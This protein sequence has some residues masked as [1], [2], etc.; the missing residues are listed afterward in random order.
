MPN[1]IYEERWV[2]PANAK[3]YLAKQ[4]ANRPLSYSVATRYSVDMVEDNWMDTGENIKLNPDGRML[5]GQHRMQAIILA[6]EL[7]EREGKKFD[8]LYLTFALNVPNESR[9]AMDIGKK[10]TLADEIAFEGGKDGMRVAAIVAWYDAFENANYTFSSGGGRYKPTQAQALKRWRENQKL[11]HTTAL[12]ATDTYRQGLGA[13]AP[14]GVAY[15]VLRT[16]F[17][18]DLVEKFW[19]PLLSGANLGEKSPILVLRNKLLS[20]KYVKHDRQLILAL[21]FKAWNAWIDEREI[22]NLYFK[23]PPTNSNFPLPRDPKNKRRRVVVVVDG[24]ALA[25]EED[26]DASD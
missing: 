8:G 15:H 22:D 10:R 4:I 3:D 9:E 12:R 2:T 26:A 16:T 11:F 14:L 19:G 5:D 24:E 6:A 7:A 1:I 17:G 13:P 21:V 20:G 18:D 25:D 23:T